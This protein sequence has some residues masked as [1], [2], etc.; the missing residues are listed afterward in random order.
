MIKDIAYEHG[1]IVIALPSKTTHK[2]QPL[3]VGVFATIQ[4][5]WSRHVG[6]LA[7]KGVMINRYNFIPEYMSIR[8]CV[9]PSIVQKSF[10]KTGIYPLNPKI[11]TDQDFAPSKATSSNPRVRLQPYYLYNHLIHFKPYVYP[12]MYRPW[13]PESFT[14]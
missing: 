1:I 8:D 10:K 9:T 4:R 6:E 11:F 2:T 5:K 7:C 12:F 13:H 3:D 14:Q